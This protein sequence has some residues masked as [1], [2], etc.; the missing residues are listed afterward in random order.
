MI[1]YAMHEGWVDIFYLL[2][3]HK[4][5]SLYMENHAHVSYN[6]L[7]LMTIDAYRLN[8]IL[9]HGQV[10]YIRIKLLYSNEEN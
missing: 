5:V 7:N 10:N 4:P 8:M 9:M 3:Y 1:F 2:W 6:R